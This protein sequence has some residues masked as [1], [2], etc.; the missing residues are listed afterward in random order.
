[1]RNALHPRRRR[2]LALVLLCL[3]LP[4]CGVAF[5]F[6]FDGTEVFRDLELEGDMQP[7]TPIAV[8]LTVRQPY[9]VPLAISCRYENTDLTDDQRKV[10]F[11]ERA[12]PVYDTVLP[13]APESRLGEDAEDPPDIEHRFEFA[14]EEPGEYFIACFT[15]AAPEHGIG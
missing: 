1:H 11:A 5:S 6:E 4:A 10:I 7:G 15:V 13:P 14:V 8:T 3:A 9:P 12:I 2:L